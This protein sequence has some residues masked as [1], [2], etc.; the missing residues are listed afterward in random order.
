MRQSCGTIHRRIRCSF[1]PNWG[2]YGCWPKSSFFDDRIRCWHSYSFSLH[3]ATALLTDSQPQ[4]SN[5]KP[6]LFS[7]TMFC[8]YLA[9]HLLTGKPQ[10][11]WFIGQWLL[12][13]R[14]QGTQ[15]DL[16]EHVLFSGCAIGA[17]AGRVFTHHSAQ[18]F[19][20]MSWSYNWA[21]ATSLRGKAKTWSW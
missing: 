18:N 11:V 6:L 3:T 7:F 14:H 5:R 16:E 9:I 12:P 8:N 19:H 15:L 2:C 21:R 10:Q 20:L 17:C 4:L 13:K 1:G